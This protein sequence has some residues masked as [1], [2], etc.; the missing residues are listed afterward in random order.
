VYPRDL[1]F[2]ALCVSAR[3]GKSNGNEAGVSEGGKVLYFWSECWEQF[4]TT[5]LVKK[6]S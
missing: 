4:K 2:V 5:A 3:D 6:Q 1:T